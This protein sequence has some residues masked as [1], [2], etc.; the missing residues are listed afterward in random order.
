MN[1]LNS[2]VG[3]NSVILT[4]LLVNVFK[5][6]IGSYAGKKG[7]NLATKE[8][9][10]QLTKIA[11]GI[12]AKISDEVWDRQKQWKL[13]RDVVF[14]AIRALTELDSAIVSMSRN[15][16]DNAK[17]DFYQC[18]SIYLRSMKMVDVVVGGKLSKHLSEYHERIVYL[19][20]EK[21][22]IDREI[23]E[24]LRTSEKQ[25]ILSARE[26]LGI[27]DAGDLPEQ[28]YGNK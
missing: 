1:V 20:Q 16:N 19:M 24:R 18:N 12:K 17:E 15:N 7:E 2:L 5:P 11:E 8:D 10:A 4:F 23:Q 14:D 28:G 6:F 26:V 9:I 27:I 21:H 25:V 3:L 13:K 22:I